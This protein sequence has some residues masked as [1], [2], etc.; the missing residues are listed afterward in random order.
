LYTKQIGKPLPAVIPEGA[1]IYR[2]L[3]TSLTRPIILSNNCKT[4]LLKK[5]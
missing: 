3:K 2:K 1:F 5:A 4:F